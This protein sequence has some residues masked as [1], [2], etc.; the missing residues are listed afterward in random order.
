MALSKILGDPAVDTI[1]NGDETVAQD[2]EVSLQPP[3]QLKKRI[4]FGKVSL[5]SFVDLSAGDDGSPGSRGLTSRDV[6]DKS[7]EECEFSRRLVA[8]DTRHAHGLT[9]TRKL[10][11]NAPT[12]KNSTS[13]YRYVRH[14]RRDSRHELTESS[15]DVMVYCNPLRNIWPAFRKT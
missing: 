6:N 5:Q 2:A 11:R 14:L 12:L 1:G 10:R 7:V 3:F 13:P 8:A 15:S 4:D 9:E